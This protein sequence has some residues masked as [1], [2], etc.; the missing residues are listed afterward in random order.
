MSFIK[1]LFDWLKNNKLTAALA[2]L[3][4]YLLISGNVPVNLLPTSGG[5]SI[6]NLSFG[7]AD[8][9]MEMA[10]PE[11][12][13][14]SRGI[15][16]PSLPGSKPAPTTDVSERLV[17]QETNISLLVEDVRQVSDQI[18][19]KVDEQDGY[20]VSSTITQPQEAPFGTIVI[21]V[22]SEKLKETMEFF[23]SLAI[24]VTSE[25]L[26]GRDVTDEYVDIEE[27][28]R[29]LEKTKKRFEE[30]MDQAVDIDDILRVQR[31]II[32]LQSQIDNLKGREQY[33]VQT[34][35]LARITVYLS[36]DEIALPYAPSDTFRP[37]VIFKMA[38]RSLIRN[39]RKIATAGIWIAV[40]SVLWVPVLL[41][42][43]FIKRLRK[44]SNPSQQ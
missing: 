32:S 41:I 12:L 44:K 10:A 42:V 25:H 22:P 23:R 35:K 16:L 37:N 6:S 43:L 8:M 31:E 24:K 40:F 4:L 28:L 11:S 3:V 36:T 13:G 15:S 5:Q 21:R 7:G 18:L 9:A 2:L 34:A 20:M 19:S 17:V 30:I 27:R 29:T 1:K 26:T 33:L 14:T 39:L 38:T